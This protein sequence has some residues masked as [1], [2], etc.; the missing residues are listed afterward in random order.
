MNNISTVGKDPLVSIVTI[1]FNAENTIRMT[2]ESVLAQDFTNYEYIIKDGGSSD[3]TMHIVNS[4]TEAFNNKGISFTVISASDCGIYDAMNTGI[5]TARGTWINFMNSG[6]CF[7]SSTVLSDV[8]NSHDY[9]SSSILF[10]D[11]IEYEYNRFYLFEKRPDRIEDVMPFSH[12]SV[13]AKRS[14]MKEYPFN[15]DYRYSADYDFLLTAHGLGLEFTDTGAVICITTKD[16]ISSVNYHD[17]LMESADIRK[18][19]NMMAMSETELAAVE[20]QLV[21]KQFVLDRFPTFIKKAIRGLQITL[22][23]QRTKVTVPPWYRK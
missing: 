14:L 13:F 8:F 11:C 2:M 15:T 10:G 20:K 17:M 18:A 22:R 12:Q 4:F 6:D 21:R 5:N 9:S 3:N 1:C 7:Y 23:H 19:H 16:G